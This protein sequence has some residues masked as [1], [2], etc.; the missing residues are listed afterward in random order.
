MKKSFQNFAILLFLMFMISCDK[1]QKLIAE[2]EGEYEVETI[3]NFQNGQGIPA[4]FSAGRIYFEDCKMKDGT[5]GNC[6]GWYEFEGKSRVTFQYN[7][8]KEGDDKVI[9][10]TN[11]SNFTEPKIMGSFKFEIDGN[12]LILNGIEESGGADGSTVKWYSDIRLSK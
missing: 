5:A 3:I 9:A 8:R 4:T 7:T 1:D 6:N 11:L 12:N 10:I 2:I